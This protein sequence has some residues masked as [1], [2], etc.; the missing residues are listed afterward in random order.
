MMLLQHKNEFY[1]EVCDQM[2]TG[3][4]RTLC[5]VRLKGLFTKYKT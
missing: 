2:V 5:G 4:L 3:H 1:I